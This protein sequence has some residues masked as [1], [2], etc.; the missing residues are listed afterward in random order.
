MLVYQ[1]NKGVN[2]IFGYSDQLHFVGMP[3]T[4]ACYIFG[5]FY[6]LPPVRGLPVYSRRASIKS[7]LTLDLWYKFNIADVEGK[8]SI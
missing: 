2:E 3:V 1:V 5:D 7:F 8:I 6:Q 4:V